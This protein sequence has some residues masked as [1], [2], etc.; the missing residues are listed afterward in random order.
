MK[1]SKD[2]KDVVLEI[3]ELQLGEKPELKDKLEDDLGMD[4]LDRIELVMDIET[5]LNISMADEEWG[6]WETVQNIVDYV[7][8]K[9]S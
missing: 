6:K 8:N 7:E 4:G 1:M 5:K 2:V 3:I 9:V